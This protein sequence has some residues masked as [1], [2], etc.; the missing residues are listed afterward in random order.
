[1]CSRVR[2]PILVKTS[3]RANENRENYEIRCA[4]F[5]FPCFH[6]STVYIMYRVPVPEF[7]ML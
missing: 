6:S 1:M 7:V 3:K 2:E 4:I 5:E